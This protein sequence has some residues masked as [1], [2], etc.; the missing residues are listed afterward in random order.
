MPTTTALTPPPSDESK[1]LYEETYNIPKLNPVPTFVTR[2]YRQGDIATAMTYDASAPGTLVRTFNIDC[3]ATKIWERIQENEE[4]L[5]ELDPDDLDDH[6]HIIG[7]TIEMRSHIGAA[8]VCGI[9][10]P[11]PTGA[12][13]EDNDADNS[14]PGLVFQ[15]QFPAF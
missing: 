6:R 9:E 4:S 15:R 12:S 14:S 3:D 10:L 8:K 2:T 1:L 7:E 11:E 5:T 13:E